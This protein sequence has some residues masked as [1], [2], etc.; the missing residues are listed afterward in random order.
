MRAFQKP[1]EIEGRAQL[2]DKQKR[3]QLD[4]KFNEQIGL[5]WYCAE[6]MNRLSGDMRQATRD[7]VKPQPR[8]CSKDDS[9]SNIVIC[10]WR[11][12]TE[13]GSQRGWAKNCNVRA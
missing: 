7:H 2:T 6:I 12:N 9:D 13:K 4:R 11:C 1:S 3:A 8:S 5:C 10:C